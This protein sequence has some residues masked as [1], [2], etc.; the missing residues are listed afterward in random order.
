[1]RDTGPDG[2]RPMVEVSAPAATKGIS[3]ADPRESSKAY[4]AI[5]K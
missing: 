1:M 4:N 2:E 3:P 5:W